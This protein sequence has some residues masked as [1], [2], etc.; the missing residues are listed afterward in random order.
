MRCHDRREG[1]TP[2]PTP[3]PTEGKRDKIGVFLYDIFE[4]VLMVYMFLMMVVVASIVVLNYSRSAFIED[5][6]SGMSKKSSGLVLLTNT[7][8]RASIRIPP[9]RF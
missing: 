9:R 6:V 5:P 2:A 8:L 1:P 4:G 3:A 7:A